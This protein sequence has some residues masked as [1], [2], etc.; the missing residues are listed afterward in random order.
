MFATR[1]HEDLKM[2]KQVYK[3]I[4]RSLPVYDVAVTKDGGK[5]TQEDPPA[6]RRKKSNKN[7]L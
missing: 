3:R 2:L 5:E 6:K 4:G 1:V 7:D